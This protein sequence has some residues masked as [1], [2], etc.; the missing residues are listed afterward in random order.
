MNQNITNNSKSEIKK[1]FQKLKTNRQFLT[2]LIL[3]FVSILFWITVSLTSSQSNDEISKE[4]TA[5]AK[6]L[7]PNFD[8][9][10]L[11]KIQEKHSYSEKE[12]SSFVIYK[13]LTSRDGKTEKVVP[14]EVTIDDLDPKQEVK[15][16][17]NKDSGSL[18]QTEIES[19]KSGDISES[20]LEETP[21][22]NN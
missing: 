16:I 15:P 7:T 5:L 1:D 21:P 10:V 14:L 4:L 17:I 20:A 8:R 3:L 11:L 13:I 22:I 2:I 19:S 9:D 18:L 6:P 12:L